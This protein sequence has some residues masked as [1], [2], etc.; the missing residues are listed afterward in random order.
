MIL[1]TVTLRIFFFGLI[2]FT[3]DKF[4]SGEP[5]R[6]LMIDAR[7]PPVASDGCPIHVHTPALFR[8]DKNC[9]TP[10][11][12]DRGL[13]RCD[14][15]D[16]YLLDIPRSGFPLCGIQAQDMV[17]AI[18][19]QQL[20][21]DQSK[22]SLAKKAGRQEFDQ[23]VPKMSS[24]RMYGFRNQMKLKQDCD[25]Q[26]PN[27]N[28]PICRLIATQINF[29]PDTFTTCTLS[30]AKLSFRPL[31]SANLWRPGKRE[32]AETV[33][34][35]V[36]FETAEAEPQ[37]VSL[38]AVAFDGGESFPIQVPVFKIE[39]EHYADIVL[40]NFMDDKDH[41]QA[42][43]R[44]GADLVA[45]DFE[46]FH[47]LVESPLYPN[48]RPIPQASRDLQEAALKAQ[49][50]RP[51]CANSPVFPVLQTRILHAGKTRPICPEVAVEGN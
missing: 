28:Q 9:T 26:C 42:Y 18:H 27:L 19:P 10:C 17:D 25:R 49:P 21:S 20:P 46:L 16:G 47:D 37:F 12:S 23:F 32:T 4:V 45:R 35:T 7:R 33:L 36:P 6:A 8:E 3:P 50:A 41:E 44:C 31:S 43:A 24:L 51:E 48:D 22:R 40:A 2:A 30:G 29:H 14:L 39:T 38:S 5:M 13:C 1:T 34:F 15:G 11:R